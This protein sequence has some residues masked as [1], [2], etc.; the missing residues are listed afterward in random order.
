MSN[1][2]KMPSF[3]FSTSD[4][5]GK[6]LHTHESNASSWRVFV[7]GEKNDGKE[8]C[9]VPA[10]PM[11]KGDW[12]NPWEQLKETD[13]AW[14]VSSYLLPKDFRPFEVR[15]YV[16]ERKEPYRIEHPHRGHSLWDSGSKK[17]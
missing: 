11:A 15:I 3:S 2:E 13:S 10:E 14:I 6:M 4:G 12:L 5:F 16:P 8:I 17:E 1:H 7:C 9:E